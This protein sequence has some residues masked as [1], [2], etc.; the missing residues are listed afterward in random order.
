M[1]AWFCFESTTL[2]IRDGGFVFGHA[3]QPHLQLTMCFLPMHT[4]DTLKLHNG[5]PRV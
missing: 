1:L 2:T 3:Y 5:A 4:C